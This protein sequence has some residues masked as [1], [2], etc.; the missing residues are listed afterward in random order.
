MALKYYNAAAK[1]RQPNP[2][3]S[4]YAD[5]AAMMDLGFE[6]APNVVYD[7]IEYE[8]T[9]GEEDFVTIPRVRVDTIL[10]YNTGI[11]LGDDYKT[12]IFAPEF[13]V[14]P[15]YGMKFRWQGSYWLVI[16]TN[17]YASLPVSAEVRRCNNVLRFFNEKGERVYE[18]CIMDYT[19]RFANNEDTMTIAIGNGEQ[20]VWCQR[21][22][23]TQLIQPNE[24]FLF[25]TPE[26]RVAF[27]LYA[28]GVKNYLNGVTMDDSSP[29]ITE[30]YVDHYE[31]NPLFDDLENGFANAYLNEVTIALNDVEPKMNIGD[32]DIVSAIVKRGNTILD[33]VNIEWLSSDNDVVSVSDGV[34]TAN[35]LGDAV[36]TATI[37][38]TN[39]STTVQVSV[40]EEEVDDI[41]ELLVSPDKDY[42][43][44]GVS[45]TFVVD[46][47]KNGVKQPDVVTFADLSTGIPVGKYT[48]TSDVQNTFTLTNKGMYMG[49]PVIVRCVSGSH[50]LTLYIKL[51]GLY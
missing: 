31:I 20:K 8:A 33:N 16:N 21:N 29:T 1:I 7:E 47:Y 2:K 14:Q 46:L 25:G 3:A 30:F 19:L 44:Q 10:N 35:S 45:E 11:I 43:L 6:N 32:K 12:F 23:R 41:Y 15:Y 24:R 42:V 4:Y 13:E 37:S 39:I 48:I 50:E 40:V 36:I 49:A 5:Y 22:S 27:R 38:D 26:Q 17:S 51:R 34:I 28:G 9:Y 18:P